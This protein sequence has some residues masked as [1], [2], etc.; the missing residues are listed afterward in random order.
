M[1]E[2]VILEA[3]VREGKGKEFARKI[4]GSGFIPAIV[5]GKNKEPR[6]LKV[7]ARDLRLALEASGG[8]LINL[9]VLDG[10]REES[11]PVLVTEVQKDPIKR[12]TLHVDFHAISLTE[13]VRVMVPVTLSG[14]EK[15]VNDG[16][17]LQLMVTEVE[18]ECLPTDIPEHI[19]ADV[20]NLSIGKSLH[21][22]E[23]EVPGGVTLLTP[24][25]EVIV[26]VV[27][28]AAE[29]AEEEVTEEGKEEKAGVDEKKDEGNE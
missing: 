15:R 16:G 11:Y 1:S 29:V 28:P 17:I 19:Q 22:G 21:A 14:E 23:L 12:E 4:R 8:R 13:K 2:K 5:Y 10:G 24:E 18:V 7:R 25:E 6:P 20:S 9:K 3:E 26:S 27:A